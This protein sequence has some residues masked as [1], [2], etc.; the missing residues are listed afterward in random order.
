MDQLNFFNIPLFDV[1]TCAVEELFKFKLNKI[2]EFLNEEEKDIFCQRVC[3]Y[4]HDVVGFPYYGEEVNLTKELERF[5]NYNPTRLLLEE[6]EL[7]QVMFG[8]SICNFFHPHM[9]D[10]KCRNQKTPKEVFLDKELF[11]KAIRKRLHMSDSKLGI[12]NIRKSLKIFSGAQSV[13]NFKPTIARYMY[14]TYCGEG[15]KVLDP[16]MGYGGRLLGSIVSPTVSSYHGVDPCVKTYDGNCRLDVELNDNSNNKFF[17][18]PF[19]DFTTK[20]LYDFIF[21]SPPYF[22]LEK[23]SDE[24]TQSYIRYPQYD[25]WIKY[26]LQPLIE[27]SYT[28]LK[29]GK[30]FAI[31]IHGEKL[32]KEIK[33][34]CEAKGFKL[35]NTLHMRLSRIPGR[36]IN[37]NKIKF[38]TE[39]IFIW[40][41]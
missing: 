36:G 41:K 34:L 4:Y 17:N 33:P 38:K 7:Q 26:F 39:P 13:S 9:W 29:K 28:Y 18:I 30:Y 3:D 37:K 1:R 16:C 5:K 32:I 35:E 40:K 21:T 14:T 31:N 25:K 12:F 23:Y 24:P 20:E 22:D 15:S 2:N 11:K 8:L 27:K 6:N 19:E 10:V